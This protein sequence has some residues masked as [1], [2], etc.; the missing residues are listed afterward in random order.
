MTKIQTA[1][2]TAAFA[3]FAMAVLFQAAP[4]KAAGEAV[5][6][7]Q[8]AAGGPRL[9]I[10]T[11]CQNDVTV[12]QVQNVGESWPAPAIVAVYTVG[13]GTVV[14]QRR[15]R[16][17]ANQ[18]VTFRIPAGAAVADSMNVAVVGP[19]LERPLQGSNTISCG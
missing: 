18:T 12:F 7:A 19:W 4:V 11:A 17:T 2:K 10:K 9:A 16:M 13:Q 15:V 6:L 14:V 5:E 8:G 1:I 3:I